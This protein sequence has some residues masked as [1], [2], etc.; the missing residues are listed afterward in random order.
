VRERTVVSAVVVVEDVDNAVCVFVVV[1]VPK[2]I[3]VIIGSCV[4]VVE[5]VETVV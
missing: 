1:V 5:D 2:E 3:R 4:V